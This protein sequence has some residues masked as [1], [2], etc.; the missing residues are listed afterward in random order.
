MIQESGNVSINAENIFP[1]IKKWLYSEKDIFI[2]ELVSNCS[3]AIHK[4]QKLVAIGEAPVPEPET[5]EAGDGSGGGYAITVLVEKAEKRLTF[6]DN[7]IGMTADEV[8]NYINQVAFSGA[9]DFLQKYKDKISEDEQI[10]GHFGLG[11]YSAF[12]V[13]EKVTIDTRSWQ[14]DA[15]AVHWVSE[16][17]MDY[18]I[19]QSERAARGT[20]VSLVMAEDSAEFLDAYKMR[21]VLRKYCAFMPYPIIVVDADQEARDAEKK[22]KDAAQEHDHEHAREHDHAHADHEHTHDHEHDHDHARDDEGDLDDDIDEESDVDDVDLDGGQESESKK[23]SYNGKEYDPINDT[24]PL[25]QKAPKDCTDEEYKA[26]YRKVFMDFDEPLFWIHLNLD[27]P[28]NLKGILYFPKLRHEFETMEG[29]IKL[30]YNQVF[31]A[32]NIKEV[33]PEFLLLLKGC[34]D[35]PD[36]PLNVSRSFLQNDSYV[37]KISAHITKKVGDKLTSLFETA[38]EDYNKYWDDI[39]PFIKYGCLKEDN[40]YDRV[41]DIIIYKDIK[42]E[43]VTLKGYLEAAKAK[44]EN[45]VFYVT[46]EAQQAQYIKMFRDNDMDAV[47]LKSMLDSHFIQFLETKENSVKLQRIDSDVS[48]SLKAADETLPKEE[49]E[50]VAKALETAFKR[51]SGN[52]QI[53]LRLEPLKAKSV[54]GMIVLSEYSRRMQDMSRMYGGGGMDMSAMFPKDETLILNSGN[55]LIRAVAKLERE[56]EKQADVDLICRHVY[57]MAMMSN[58]PL[59][60]A[61]MTAFLE[62]SGQLL[63]KLI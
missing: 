40:F 13:A 11:F 5:G 59:E 27:Y 45:T 51:A 34:L 1:I 33:I 31:V 38:R 19:S 29:Q 48:E 17:G 4:H 47:I 58:K 63:E 43:Y 7:G 44:H 10:I 3:D 50:S 52:E 16:G 54:P 32:D 24:V 49:A 9:Q 28:F 25:W 22:E 6:I 41:K 61:A 53:K 46:D 39:N 62:R 60:P 23:I 57:D 36:L 12:M 56:N 20:A 15:E 18:A 35:C 26:F 42:G 2:R 8:K 37:K 55:P 14:P 21:E 30:Y